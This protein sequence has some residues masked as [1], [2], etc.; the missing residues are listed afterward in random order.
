MAGTQELAMTMMNGHGGTTMG[1]QLIDLV[2][3]T[4]TV[5]VN[6]ADFVLYPITIAQFGGLM[7]AYPD[8]IS[9]ISTS[10]SMGQLVIH[11]PQVVPALICASLRQPEALGA[12]SNLPLELQIEFL[13]KISE[14]SIPSGVRPL[15]EMLARIVT[16]RP[17]IPGNRSGMQ[18][19]PRTSPN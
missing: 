7:A 3:I 14:I 18:S 19:L 13:D 2:P 16:G 5:Q 15:M 17:G 4:S 8:L 1:A 6:G 10:G 12:A 9:A 11:L